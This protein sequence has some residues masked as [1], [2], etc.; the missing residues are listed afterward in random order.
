M[1]ISFIFVMAF[2]DENLKAVAHLGE[3][4]VLPNLDCNSKLLTL[5]T[6]PSI[7]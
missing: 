7:S 2:S 5:K 4:E 1:A 3:L 6:R